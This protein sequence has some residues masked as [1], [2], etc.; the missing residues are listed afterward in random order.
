[1]MLTNGHQLW[2]LPQ[3]RKLWLYAVQRLIGP[4][5]SCTP[6]IGTR[7]P[8]CPLALTGDGWPNLLS[9]GISRQ[10]SASIAWAIE[11]QSAHCGHVQMQ[12]FRQLAAKKSCWN[13]STKEFSC[14]S[15]LLVVHWWLQIR[16]P[17]QLGRG[18]F[19]CG[20]G[21]AFTATNS[22]GR[23]GDACAAS[24]FSELDHNA[25]LDPLSDRA[26]HRRH[27]MGQRSAT[28][29]RKPDDAD[30]VGTDLPRLWQ[31][32]DTASCHMSSRQTGLWRIFQTV[33]QASSKITWRKN[34]LPKCSWFK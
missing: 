16:R 10:F 1:M 27:S 19:L 2:D 5:A 24:S 21:K 4:W 26:W 30:I 28:Q 34:L 7:Q 17:S 3:Y 31:R 12:I 32:A 23:E 13:N 8:G 22:R 33:N 29:C 18:I 6:V 14:V 11:A 15:T 20:N 9:C 25:G